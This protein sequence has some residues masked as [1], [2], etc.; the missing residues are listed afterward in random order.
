MVIGE[1]FLNVLKNHRNN[2]SQYKNND[3]NF[4][5]SRLMFQYG[6]APFLMFNNV[7]KGFTVTRGR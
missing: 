5:D 1:C 6:T 7:A 2:E 4:G 3:Q